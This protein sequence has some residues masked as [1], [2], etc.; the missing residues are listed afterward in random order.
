MSAQCY[1]GAGS[2]FIL[3]RLKDFTRAD[4]ESLEKLVS[5]ALQDF[6]TYSCLLERFLGFFRPLEAALLRVPGLSG[7]IPDLPKRNRS[8]LLQSDLAALGRSA[9]AMGSLPDCPDLP[10]LGTIAEALGCLYVLEG[11][12][13][14][15]QVVARGLEKLGLAAAA[16]GFFLSGGCNVGLMWKRLDA[17]MGSYAAVYPEQ[18]GAICES[19]QRTFRSLEAWIAGA[20]GARVARSDG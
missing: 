12:R 17:A 8:G 20:A 9:S 10:P 11:S 13:L 4:H 2:V 14:G 18:A 16:R 1:L 3:T 5:P 6:L 19:A 7:L 15:G